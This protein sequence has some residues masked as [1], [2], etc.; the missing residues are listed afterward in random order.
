LELDEGLD[1]AFRTGRDEDDVDAA[2]HHLMVEH[3]ATGK[4]IGT[5][6]LMVQPM[7]DARGGFYSESE[8]DF[9][10]LPRE[11][12]EDGVELG[13]ACVHADHRNGRVI[14]LLWRG[15]GR[16]VTWN[17]KRYLFGCCSLPT[18]DEGVALR[19]V[20]HLSGKG[21]VHPRWHVEAHRALRLSASITPA[22]IVPEIPP[23]LESYLSLGARICGAPAVDRAFKVIDLFVVL[24]VERMP[25]R[26]R[27]S[28]TSEKRWVAA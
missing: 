16:Y 3:R 4:V 2:C 7:A 22:R 24:D 18:L 5:Y 10:A 28:L 20:M 26:A 27:E 1:S 23:L 8:Y 9:G 17:Q 15:L 11:V 21:H 12:T 6:R 14:H 13:R 19:A 25:P